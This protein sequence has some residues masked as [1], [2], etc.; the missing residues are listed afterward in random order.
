MGNRQ[1]VHAARA[2]GGAGII[3]GSHTGG[4]DAFGPTT[5]TAR[6]AGRP[7]LPTELGELERMFND[8]L[9]QMD[10]PPERAKHLR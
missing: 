7:G 4:V 10:L 3:H 6:K 8:V 2:N 1:S 5:M 9:V